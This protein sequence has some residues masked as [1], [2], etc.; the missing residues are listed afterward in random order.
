MEKER[1]GWHQCFEEMAVA[2]SRYRYQIDDGMMVPDPASRFQPEGVHGLSAVTDPLAWHWHDGDWSGRPLEEAVFYELHVGTFSSSGTFAGVRGRLDYLVEL[3]VTAIELMPVAAFAGCR[4]WGYD[5]VLPFAPS[6][7]YGTPEEL[8][9][10]IEAAHVRRLMVFLDVVYNHFGPEGNYLHLYAPAFFTEQFHTPWGA[11]IRFSGP[12]SR[13]VRQFFIENALY[14]LEEFHF[15]GLRL[16]AVHAI[17]DPS[18]PDILEEM[19]VAV[20][21]GM[22][23]KRQVHLILENDGNQVRYL[24]REKN[25]RP[26][27]Y[28]S[29]W[30]DDAHHALHVLL[31]GERDGYYADYGETAAGHLGR[32]LA[33]GF[34][35]QGEVSVWR[36][37]RRR[38]TPSVLLPPAAFINFLQNHDQIGN[39]PFGER[40]T[41]LAAGKALMAAT[42]ILLLSPQLPLLFMGQEW[43][44]R[45]PFLY[46]CDFGDDLAPLVRDGRRREFS[47]FDAFT[48]KELLEGIPDPCT[49]ETFR[50]CVLDWDSLGGERQRQWLGLHR[51]LLNIR[52]RSI[53]PRLGGVLFRGS[54]RLPAEKVLLVEWRLADD[55]KLTLTANFDDRSFSLESPAGEPLYQSEGVEAGERLDLP[56]W[57]VA[58]FLYQQ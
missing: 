32:C 16:D 6:A 31:T 18:R 22:G 56:P 26:S 37:G 21:E 51:R 50:R 25:G 12:H 10:L 41:V 11:A 13:Q 44:C 2:G 4:N 30:N 14:W 24:E 42:A 49:E 19:A 36:G 38:G 47:R 1:E 33:E 8:K 28:D 5:G 15:D 52:R 23:K 58:F 9:A 40:V 45:L 43:G 17:F 54:Y 48:K 34:A 20:R 7:C 27:F 29:Q 55:A 57:S 39:R 46:F 53:V 3:G 35:Y